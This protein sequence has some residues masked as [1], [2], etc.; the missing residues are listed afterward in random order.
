MNIAVC[1]VNYK[2][3]HDTIAC[4][5]SLTETGYE[6]QIILV[7]DNNSRDDSLEKIE[8]AMQGYGYEKNEV[9]LTLNHAAVNN[10]SSYEHQGI[11]VVLIE[12]NENGGFAFGCNIGIRFALENYKLDYFWLL[13]N[14]TEVKKNIYIA[15]NEYISKKG[16]KPDVLG[17]KLV[18]WHDRSKIQ[19]IGGKYNKFFSRTKH[20]GANWPT[21][22]NIEAY[23]VKNLD[24]LV[25]ASLLLKYETVR[26]TGYLNEEYFLYFEEI[27][28]FYRL[29][30]ESKVALM[31]KAIVYHKEGA[32]IKGK[33][34]RPIIAEYYNMKS[35]LIF[36]RKHHKR[37]LLTVY[38]TM[39]LTIAKR[40]FEG[41]P[42]N[43]K[44]IA[45]LLLKTDER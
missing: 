43:A 9:E 25:G 7:V 23:S 29:G 21:E 31:N 12:S 15:I 24:Y 42:N 27:D 17:T 45:E 30:K 16:F 37:Y 6:D 41:K 32:S 28:Y 5:T 22:Y 38:I 18:Y 13:N 34:K 20:I 39:I 44:I 11:K 19:A 36:T 14:D 2:N 35:R 3:A 26:H 1:I 33:N 4:I 8:S 10:I 40:L